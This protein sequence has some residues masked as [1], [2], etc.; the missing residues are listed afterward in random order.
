MSSS[1]NRFTGSVDELHGVLD[2]F[3]THVSWLQYQDR[4]SDP[5]KLEILVAHKF[6]LRALTRISPN[7][8]FNKTQLV[9]V[10]ERLHF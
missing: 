5:V 10:F 4:V 8:S 3:V 6:L 2:P 7:L 9:T 1:R